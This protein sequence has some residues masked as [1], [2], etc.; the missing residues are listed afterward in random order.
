MWD[1]PFFVVRDSFL[2]PTNH[3]A[4]LEDEPRIENSC[5]HSA[6]RLDVRGFL[7]VQLMSYHSVF[8]VQRK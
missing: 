8:Y 2:L 3:D 6:S 7:W 5:H 4:N 1:L